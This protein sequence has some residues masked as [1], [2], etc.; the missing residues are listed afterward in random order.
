MFLY[1]QD[2]R[3]RERMVIGLTTTYATST[4]QY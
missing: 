4:Y 3:G 1:F 2:R